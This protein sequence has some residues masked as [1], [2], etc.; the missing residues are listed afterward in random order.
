MIAVLQ[1]PQCF[2]IA[3]VVVI[4]TQEY[5]SNRRQIVEANARLTHAPGP[6]PPE[7]SGALREDRVGD[8][9]AGARLNQKGRVTDE[10]DDDLV[11][12]GRR[13]RGPL[14]D[15][16]LRRPWGVTLEQHARRLPERLCVCAVRVEEP[17][18][19]EMIAHL[20]AW[21]PL[22]TDGFPL[23]EISVDDAAR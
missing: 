19:V 16:H 15:W 18:V 10:G 21:M 11:A 14:H 17:P 3:V 2:Q 12:A 13:R 22:V 8:D 6:C 20:F 1:R 23:A 9:V 7:R 4:V 5:V